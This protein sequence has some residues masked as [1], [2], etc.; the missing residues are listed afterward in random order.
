MPTKLTLIRLAERVARPLRLVGLGP[1]IDKAAGRM[2]TQLGSM[3]VEFEGFV[4]HCNQIGHVYYMRDLLEDEHDRYFRK[5]F[6]EAIP[7]GG[8]VLEGGA[9]LGVMTLCAARSVGPTGRVYTFEPNPETLP[10]LHQNIDANGYTNCATVIPLGLA[11]EDNTLTFYLSGGGETSSIHDPGTATRSITINTIAADD[12]FPNDTRIDVVKL[13]IEGNEVAAVVG[14][15]RLL[16]EADS[17]ITVFAECNPEMLRRAGHTPQDLIDA[18]NEC[19]LTVRWIDD[20]ECRIRAID[21]EML[22]RGYVNLVC[23]RP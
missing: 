14:M 13:D 6:S 1:L 11:A 8:T 18:L 12:W 7:E 15:K 4:I 17:N 21:G 3:D 23:T 22:E 2:N 20:V 5:L 10:I 19:N 16:L 9:H